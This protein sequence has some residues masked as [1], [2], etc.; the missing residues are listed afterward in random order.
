MS[1]PLS[2]ARLAPRIARIIGLLGL[3]VALSACSAIKLG[4][5]TLPQLAYWWLDGFLD[6]DDAQRHRVREDLA[7]LH[8]WHRTQEL[9]R[10]MPLLQR[11]ERL[12]GQD[13]TAQQVCAFEPDLRERLA[14]LREQAE[15]AVVANAM[16][17]TP[18]QVQHLE[19]KYASR[20]REFRADWVRLPPAELL[21]K[22][23]K[24]FADRAET[25][26]GNLD[27]RQREVLREQLRAS[28]YKPSVVLAERARRQQETLELLRRLATQPVPIGEARAA[29][30]AQVDRWLESPDPAYREYLASIR[31]ENCRLIAALHNATT[32]V[33][34]EH[35]VRRFR[36]WQRDHT[37]L[38]AQR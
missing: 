38:S 2:L 22:R 4:Y 30:R 17:L 8:D 35:A 9:P 15:P 29:V 7:R 23:F 3:A 12:A 36:A 14:A 13:I 27:E 21:D 11:A 6:F 26:Y 24:E 16:L 19:R 28:A 31:Q 33:Q 32:P 18:P 34:R 10:I 37:E 1:F 25:V 20:N 5:S